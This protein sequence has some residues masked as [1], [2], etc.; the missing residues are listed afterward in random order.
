MGK[1][2]VRVVRVFELR[3]SRFVLDGVSGM[4]VYC[5]LAHG[6]R[7]DVGA[8]LSTRSFFAD[9]CVVRE[10]SV[11]SLKMFHGIDYV[12]SNTSTKGSGRWHPDR[13]AH[14]WVL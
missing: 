7:E 9:D 12:R 11:Q 2:A 10:V 5:W 4:A 8:L 6:K 3:T 14:P 13:T 1:R